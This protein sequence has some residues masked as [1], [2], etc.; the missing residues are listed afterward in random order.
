[1]AI[2]MARLPYLYHASD[3]LLRIGQLLCCA[4]AESNSESKSVGVL[5]GF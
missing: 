3:L 2:G 4:A 1:M 5:S